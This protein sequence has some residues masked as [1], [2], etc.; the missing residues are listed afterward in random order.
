MKTGFTYDADGRV[1]SFRRPDGTGYDYTYDAD[2]RV[3][4]YRCTDGTGYAVIADDGTYALQRDLTTRRYT[5]GCRQ[6]LTLEQALAHWGPPRTDKRA[7]LFFA[8]LMGEVNHG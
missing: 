5:A 3:R 7:Q 4:S 2:G 1:L 6:D 8:A